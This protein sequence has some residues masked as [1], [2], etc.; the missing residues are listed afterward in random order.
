[1][2]NTLK[3]MQEAL[4][5]TDLCKY[6]D[7]SLGKSAEEIKEILK[8]HDIEVTDSTA[9][10]CYEFMKGINV[11]S[12][13]ELD[14]VAGGSCY[15]ADTYDSLGISFSDIRGQQGHY[16][17]LITTIGNSCKLYDEF[18]GSGCRGCTWVNKAS[19]TMTYYCEARSKEVD[20]A[21]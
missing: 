21:K 2:F 15:S 3:E 17:P 20:L 13:E 1:M 4:S 5:Y 11:L 14:N 6:A 19:G 10:E 8:S 12:E 18:D 7:E 9:N 16:H